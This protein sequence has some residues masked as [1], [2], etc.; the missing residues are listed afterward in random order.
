LRRIDIGRFDDG[1][2]LRITADK[3]DQQVRALGADPVGNNHYRHRE[4]E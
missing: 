2:V 3:D 4:V 1:S